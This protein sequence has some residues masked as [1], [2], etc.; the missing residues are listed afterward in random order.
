MLPGPV[1]LE[2]RLR[3]AAPCLGQ[4]DG[5]G[6]FSALIRLPVEA[7]GGKPNL[8]VLPPWRLGPAPR[9]ALLDCV[10]LCREMALATPCVMGLK[11][12]GGNA[13]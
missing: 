10:G 5:P 9:T 7:E 13:P 8:V 6:A 11:P 4:A 1:W 3:G 2:N 12:N